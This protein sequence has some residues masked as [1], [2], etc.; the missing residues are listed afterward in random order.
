[1][2]AQAVLLAGAQLPLYVD[3][4][5][6][7]RNSS[8]PP[9]CAS[10]AQCPRS[11]VNVNLALNDS[12]LTESRSHVLITAAQHA[13]RSRS[14]TRRRIAAVCRRESGANYGLVTYTY[15]SKEGSPGPP[16]LA[17]SA[18]ESRRWTGGRWSRTERRVPRVSAVAERRRGG[19][20]VFMGCCH[21]LASLGGGTASARRLSH[22]VRPPRSHRAAYLRTV[23][24][25]WRLATGA[26]VVRH[27]AD[28]YAAGH[29]NLLAAA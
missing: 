17:R 1:V 8:M 4:S 9:T 27:P 25:G 12:R 11:Q 22:S 13:A 26:S 14:R 7:R 3:V 24:L 21:W 16:P 28:P 15:G 5:E 19:G 10:C 18:T 6:N 29:T 2:A 20:L 23:R